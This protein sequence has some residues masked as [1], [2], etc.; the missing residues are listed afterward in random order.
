MKLL[1]K[2]L[3]E[4]QTKSRS[5]HSNDNAQAESKNNAIV[6]TFDD[7]DIEQLKQGGAAEIVA[8]VVEGSLMLATQTML[9]L[10][11]PLNRVLK[12]LRQVR[13]ERYQLMRSG[14]FMGATDADDPT[15]DAR[16]P[17]LHSFMVD[18]G[19]AC[20]GKTIAALELE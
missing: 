10:G 4:E 17:R 20:L 16:Q 9:L 14:F 18:S 2:L 15:F 6:R 12:R 13:S 5:R 7:S 3:V 1:N 19:A 8:E 11:V